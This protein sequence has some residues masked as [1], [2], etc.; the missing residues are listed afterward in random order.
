MWHRGE[1]RTFPVADELVLDRAPDLVRGDAVLLSDVL[2][3][4]SDHAEDPREDTALHALLGRV[5]DVTPR[6]SNPHD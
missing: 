1:V 4:V 6:V 5:S 3:L 2:K